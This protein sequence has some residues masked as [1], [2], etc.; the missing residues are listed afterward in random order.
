M[1]VFITALTIIAPFLV[2]LN[3][4]MLYSLVQKSR[5]FERALA[6]YEDKDRLE[7]E[8]DTM[9]ALTLLRTGRIEEARAVAERI[10]QS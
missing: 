10:V 1:E 4:I 2:L 8:R 6:R 9:E 5:R 7:L 3:C